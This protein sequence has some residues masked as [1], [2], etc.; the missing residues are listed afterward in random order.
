MKQVTLG[1]ALDKLR[2]SLPPEMRVKWDEQD[3]KDNELQQ[4]LR[5]NCLDAIEMIVS[6]ARHPRIALP[7]LESAIAMLVVARDCA[8]TLD[9]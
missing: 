7:D 9:K 3:R 1:D 6:A 2:A 5:T 4:V 8:K